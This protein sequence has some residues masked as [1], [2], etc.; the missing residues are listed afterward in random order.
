MS[1]RNY[2]MSLEKELQGL[3]VPIFFLQGGEDV[4]VNPYSPFYIFPN[5]GEAF[6]RYQS[7]WDHFVI[8]S[9]TDEV[10]DLIYRASR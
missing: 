4:L 2:L 8:W 7:K 9:E 5:T 3:I 10:V 1:L 6:L